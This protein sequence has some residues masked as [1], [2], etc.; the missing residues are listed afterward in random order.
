MLAT[1]DL[2]LSDGLVVIILLLLILTS[3]F[4]TLFILIVVILLFS[5][6]LILSSF[7]LVL[8][9]LLSVV[10]STALTN[11]Y[12]RN[13]AVI[14]FTSAR[15]VRSLLLK[16]LFNHGVL[17]SDGV[18]LVFFLCSSFSFGDLVLQTCSSLQIHF[19][20]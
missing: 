16:D 18:I 14:K 3:L 10:V 17:S 5:F 2:S 8:V 13:I 12:N 9:A 4:A 1:L 11:L 20:F 15:E 7:F 6:L 19:R